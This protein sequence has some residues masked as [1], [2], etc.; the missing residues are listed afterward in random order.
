V[1][2]N[3]SAN[4]SKVIAIK[5]GINEI[6]FNNSERINNKLVVGGSAGDLWGRK[7]ARDSSGN[8]M[9][10]NTRKCFPGLAGRVNQYFHFPEFIFEHIT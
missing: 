3:W 2:L 1:S 9:I 6:I 10:D 7:F 4:R 5:E 8:L